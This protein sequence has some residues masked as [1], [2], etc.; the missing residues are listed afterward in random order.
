MGLTSALKSLFSKGP[1]RTISF[2]DLNREA[3]AGTVAVVDVREPPEFASGH[4]PGAINMPLSRF[5]PGQLPTGK[6]VVLICLAGGRSGRAL[7][8]A[9]AAGRTDV[10]HYP[11]GMNGWRQA[12]GKIV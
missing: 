1:E 12:G 9:V 4:V 10:V 6:P 2:D 11:G 7:G 3:T 5:N 8:Q